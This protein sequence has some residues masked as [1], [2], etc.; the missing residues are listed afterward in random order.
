MPTLVGCLHF[1]F[2]VDAERVGDAIDV[3]E[4][5]DDFDGV[6]DIAVAQAMQAQRLEVLGAEGRGGARHH[7]RKFAQGLLARSELGTVVVVLD[8]LGQ[9]LILRLGTE[10]LSV[11]FDSIEAVIGPGNHRRQHF[12]LGAGEAGRAKHR[13]AIHLH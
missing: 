1:G 10:I 13:S 8:V 9:L 5:G 11:S 2:G 6:E 12:A 7:L 4:I 3:I